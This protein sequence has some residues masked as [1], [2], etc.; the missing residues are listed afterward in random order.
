MYCIHC[1]TQNSDS[2]RFCLKCGQPLNQ[3]TPQ[4]QGWAQPAQGWESVPQQQGWEQ[5][6]QGWESAPQPTQDW[7]A[8]VPEEAIPQPEEWAQPQPAGQ[9]A[10]Q[11]Q[12]EGAE[13]GALEGASDTPASDGAWGSAPA[14]DP[15]SIP[16]AQDIPETQAAPQEEP[17]V[18]EEP[19]AESSDPMPEAPA[20]EASAP[21]GEAWPEEEAGEQPNTGDRWEAFLDGESSQAPFS[22]ADWAASSQ[23][24]TS[25][26]D[27]IVR[28]GTWS[29]ADL[30]APPPAPVPIQEAGRGRPG[31]VVGLCLATALAG[32]GALAYLLFK[33]KLVAAPSPVFSIF[34][35]V[36][37]GAAALLFAVA[38]IVVAVTSRAPVQQVI[39]DLPPQTGTPYQPAPPA[40]GAVPVTLTDANHPDAPFQL[41]LEGPVVI[42]R[43]EG[44]CDLALPY[45]KSVSKRHCRIYPAQGSVYVEDLGG[46]NGTYLNGTQVVVPTSLH[47]GDMIKLGRLVLRIDIG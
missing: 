3:S 8:A 29:S 40:G 20:E 17:A 45:E 16:T 19:Q 22:T 47:S 43:V 35:P 32:G 25:T 4:Q 11:A 33:D 42:G 12:T 39:E 24:L 44:E 34:I 38:A 23:D 28:S 2:N 10:P 7:S 6:A 27:R 14:E 9:E 21:D 46:R 1:G 37:L 5:P 26:Q 18:W 15:E 36:S 31:L 41:L 13:D 30:A